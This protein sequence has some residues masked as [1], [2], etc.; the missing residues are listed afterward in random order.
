[1]FKRKH[2]ET[3]N[4]DDAN[5]EAMGDLSTSSSAMDT[6][7]IRIA[8]RAR[9]LSRAQRLDPDSLHAIFSL[10]VSDDRPTLCS[11]VKHGQYGANKCTYNL[12]WIKLG[13]VCRLW[14]D[15]LLGMRPLW[16]E[17][18]CTL[19]NAAMAEFVR[20]AGG[21]PLVIDLNSSG[22]FTITL[23]IMLRARIIRGLSRSEQLEMLNEQP[24]PALEIL[25]LSSN[26]FTTVNAPN[27]R[28]VTVNGNG[29]IT[30]LAPNI[31]RAKCISPATFSRSPSLRFLEFR[32]PSDHCADIPFMLTALTGLREL[33]IEIYDPDA[34]RSIRTPW[35]DIDTALNVYSR[36][37]DNLNLRFRG[38]SLSLP[39]L[40]EL[41]VSGRGVVR[42]TMCGLLAH[43]TATCAGTLRRTEVR[44]DSPHFTSS[45]LALD[46]I[47]TSTHA[48][49]VD[50]LYVHFRDVMDGVSVVLSASR[51][52]RRHD[53]D[54]PFGTFRFFIPNHMDLHSLIRERIMPLLPL[55][56]ITHLFIECLPLR[57]PLLPAQVA[58]TAALSKLTYVHTL[59]VGDNDRYPRSNESPEGLY[60]LQ[61]P[62]ENP[63]LPSLERLYVSYSRGMFRDWWKRL[64]LAL[65]VRKRA[66]VPFASVCIAHQWGSNAQR[67]EGATVSPL[68]TFHEQAVD[69][70]APDIFV[71]NAPVHAFNLD[72]ASVWA[73]EKVAA[74]AKSLF[75]EVVETIEVEEVSWLEPVWPP[76]L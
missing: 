46:A 6:H 72:G 1:M 41:R 66:G 30:L 50:A 55:R 17:N 75:T 47:R 27:L 24:L 56:R 63:N 16:A 64:A 34:E 42:R 18:V 58:L 62:P 10:V 12:G 5:G 76:N 57:T 36:N 32:R 44:C 26:T 9:I 69:L 67:R 54:C 38:V 52:E 14:R 73:K 61:G 23:D 68:E 35:Q 70:Q 29:R 48:A 31:L 60:A 20:R 53:P 25:E 2:T 37:A 65:A 8:S 49:Q 28:E 11:C 71:A 3:G 43:L 21:H 40:R 39:D 4:D 22:S 59:H 19:N 7:N 13:H 15:V 33:I 74:V 51:L 45:I